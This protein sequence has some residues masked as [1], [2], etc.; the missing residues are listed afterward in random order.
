LLLV[1]ANHFLCVPA[2]LFDYF[3]VGTRILA[4]TEEGATRELINETNSGDCF[5]AGD[6]HGM[7]EYIYKIMQDKQCRHVAPSQFRPFET[8]QLSRQLAE[9]LA[10]VTG[11]L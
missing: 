11:C 6:V 10:S 1:P 2:K 3:G 9:Q 8:K 7:E 5:S 4:V